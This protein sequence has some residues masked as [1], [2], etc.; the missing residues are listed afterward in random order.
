LSRST[1]TAV[2]L[3]LV[4]AV[5]TVVLSTPPSV[6]QSANNG[7][8]SAF[9]PLA[10]CALP[11][12]KLRKKRQVVVPVAGRC[13]IPQDAVAVTLDLQ[14]KGS[15]PGALR[16]W[17]TGGGRPRTPVLAWSAAHKA[18]ATQATS[19]LG[20]GQV[21]LAGTKGK[22]KVNAEVVGYYRQIP[23]SHTLSISPWT[24]A[25]TGSTSAGLGTSNGCVTNFDSVA[26]T[27]RLPLTLPIG[28]RITSITT[29]VYDGASPETYALNLVRSVTTPTGLNTDG[30]TPL[31]SGGAESIVVTTSTVS[32][33]QTVDA[34][35]SFAITLS[36]LRSFNNGLCAVQ[37]TYQDPA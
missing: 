5:A 37:V 29:A 30:T 2:A 14:A 34:Q 20:D 21:T 8:R 13:G 9:V 23:T 31:G 26:A 12:A 4:V 7:D 11:T 35:H 19:G 24:M 3:S 33:D 1:I 32:V 36:N 6:A 10:P 28:S 16:L 18:V 25:L 17:A 27:G 22:T 15:R